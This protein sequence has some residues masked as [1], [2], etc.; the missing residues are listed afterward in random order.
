MKV[1]PNLFI[2]ILGTLQYLGSVRLYTGNSDKGRSSKR[3]IDSR[4]LV[5]DLIITLSCKTTE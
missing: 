4:W 1:K 3:T 5:A 2:E